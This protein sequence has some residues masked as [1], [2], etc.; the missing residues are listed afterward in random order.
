MGMIGHGI[1]GPNNPLILAAAV[2]VGTAAAVTGADAMG[3][4]GVTSDWLAAP[5]VAASSRPSYPSA[6]RLY[7]GP[8]A[9]INRSCMNAIHV[10]EHAILLRC[11]LESLGDRFDILRYSAMRGNM[12]IDIIHAA[13]KRVGKGQCAIP[14][15]IV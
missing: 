8:K 5:D 6:G 13:P 9:K 4:A 14:V 7:G 2:P 1:T 10:V 3:S 11:F 12:V 15:R